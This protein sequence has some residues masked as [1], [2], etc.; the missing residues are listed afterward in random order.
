MLL[1]AKPRIWLWGLIPL[2][3]VVALIVFV[4]KSRIESDLSSRSQAALKAEG[5]DW[6]ELK[7]DGR[8]GL[9]IGKAPSE[10]ERLRALEI[11]GGVYGVRVVK[12]QLTLS[13]EISPFSWSA[14]LKDDKLVLR[15]Y[16][17]SAKLRQSVRGIAAA[18]FPQLKIVDKMKVAR[19][20]GDDAAW[21]S[22][23]RSVD[24]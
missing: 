18:K 20:A 13:D 1:K 4:D 12:D 19:G 5:I 14:G 3:L 15:E 11:V 21:L 7:F 8:D 22:R 17:P 10:G 6:A 23:I 2:L 16:V 24:L 9:I